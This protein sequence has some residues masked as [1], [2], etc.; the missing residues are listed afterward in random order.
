MIKIV[1]LACLVAIPAHSAIMAAKPDLPDLSVQKSLVKV[2][3]FPVLQNYALPWIVKPGRPV[4]VTGVVVA[5][6]LILVRAQDA[7]T[8]GLIQ[9]QK[10]SSYQFA[11]ASIVNLDM[12][13][14]LAL[15][16]VDNRGFFSDLL[17][18]SA[19]IDLKDGE[20]ATAIKVDPSFRVIR[21]KITVLDTKIVADFGLTHLPV[22]TF[23]SDESFDTGSVLISRRRFRGM[24][25]YTGKKKEFVPVSVINAYRKRTLSSQAA[26]ASI[27]FHYTDMIDNSRREYYG[28]PNKQSGALITK[29]IPGTS[30]FGQLQ[31]NDIILRIENV[32]I[33][34]AGYFDSGVTG[35]R[36][37]SMI[38]VLDDSRLR[39]PGEKL[40]VQILRKK[41][42]IPLKI[43]LK[44]YSGKAERIP[45]VVLKRPEYIVESGMVF[46]ELSVPL[47]RQA[48]GKNWQSRAIELSK[49]YKEKQYYSKVSNDRIVVISHILPDE[50]NRGYSGLPMKPV[51][52]VNGH[53]ISNIANLKQAINDAVQSSS[54][55][56][57]VVFSGGRKIYLD[58]KNR[59]QI[60][61]R[62]KNKYKINPVR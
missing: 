47:L 41:K 21:E 46:V 50:S 42:I 61:H 2:R 6:N 51:L 35:K 28:M 11:Q 30:A 43:T 59:N 57:A 13:S 52:A 27:G 17:P 14:N 24:V 16:K 38:F 15:L 19:G 53:K 9:V 8:A 56:L 40:R 18:I 49:I 32:N 23:R 54:P 55:Y 3:F 39:K 44:P 26:F 22:Q 62:I 34:N 25:S 31:K 20:M 7:R 60:N 4:N 48:F 36:P 29:V 45:W 33:D 12:E 10:Y 37:L 1:F 58:V 5:N